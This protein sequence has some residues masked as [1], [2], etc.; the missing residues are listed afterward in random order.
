MKK[1]SSGAEA[2]LTKTKSSGTGAISFLQ[3]LRSP[4]FHHCKVLHE[5][6]L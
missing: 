5:M 6:H 2:M 3:E 1:H 4:A